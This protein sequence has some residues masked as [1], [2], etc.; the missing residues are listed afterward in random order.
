[1]RASAASRASFEAPTISLLTRMSGT[2]LQARASA[3]ATF[4]THWPTAPRAICSCAMTA[5]LWVLAW[6]RSRA[7]VGAGHAVQIIFQGVEVDQQCRGVDLVLAHARLGGRR[8]QHGL[9]FVGNCVDGHQGYYFAPTNISPPIFFSERGQRRGAGL[10]GEPSH[11]VLAGSTSP[12]I[13]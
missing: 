2:P 9:S 10:A 8:L 4:W 7:P 5:D 3:S 11:A 6:A 13:K 1:M 12:F